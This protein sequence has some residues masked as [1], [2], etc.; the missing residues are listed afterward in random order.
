MDINFKAYNNFKP[1]HKMTFVQYE[2]TINGNN[3]E[4]DER[5]LPEQLNIKNG[6]TF[7]ASVNEFGKITLE[8]I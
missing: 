7:V 6:D 2:F 4:F 8:K 3:I 1:F 5:V